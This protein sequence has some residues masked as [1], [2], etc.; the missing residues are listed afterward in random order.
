MK[1]GGKAWRGYF[2]TGE[3]LTSGKIDYKEGIYFGQELDNDNPE[4]KKGTH[5]HGRS[6][7][8]SSP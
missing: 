6:L 1:K 8:P 4:V 2:S 5:L 3:E 7:F